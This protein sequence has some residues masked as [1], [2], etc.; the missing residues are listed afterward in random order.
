MN[1][2]SDKV[3]KAKDALSPEKQALFELLLNKRK[4]AESQNSSAATSA[5]SRRP[6]D[7]EDVPL[8]FAQEQFWLLD[9]IAPDS[10]VYNIPMAF[11]IVGA[12]NVTA[13][14]KSLNEVIRRHEVLRSTCTAIDGQPTQRIIPELRLSL[15]I[16]DLSHLSDGERHQAVAK[17]KDDTAHQPFD[18]A[19]GPLIRATLLLTENN[20]E[21]QEHIFLLNLHHFVADGWSMGLFYE[22]LTSLYTRL[23][24]GQPNSD[25]APLPQLPIQYGDFAHWQRQ[26]INSSTLTEQLQFWKE[27]LADVESLTLATDRPRPA[28]QNHHGASYRFTL[29]PTLS[30]ALRSLS[31]REGVTLFMTLM[32]AFQVL[33]Y[34]YTQEEDILVATAVSNRLQSETERLLGSFANNLLLR[35]KV[36]GAETFRDLL[37]QVREV[38]VKA[39]ANQEFPFAQLI[40]ELLPEQE[41]QD[42][43]RNPLFQVMFT[44]H[45]RPEERTLKLANLTVESQPIPM[46]TSK[47]DLSLTIINRADAQT[48]S[49][50]RALIAGFEYNTD[51]F[52]ENTI[53]RMADHYRVL[54]EEVVTNGD[55]PLKEISL[56]TPTERH[57]LLVGWNNTQKDYSQDQCIHQLFEQQVE[58][59]PSAI[60]AVFHDKQLTYG[61][62]NS[63][64]NQLAHYLQTLGLQP[65]EVVG[66]CLERSLEMIVALLAVL[67]AG[68]AYVPLDPHYPADRLAFMMSDAQITVL[69]TEEPCLSSLPDSAPQTVCLQRDWSEISQH[70]YQNPVT[71]ITPENLAYVIYTSG[72]TGTPK[73]VMVQHNSLVNFTH[74]AVETYEVSSTDRVLQFASISFDA[75]AEEIYPCL[76][77]GATLVLRSDDMLSSVTNFL[78]TCHE[79]QLTVLD[80][81]TA[82]WQQ[83]VV[84]LAA[85][86]LPD[87][88]RLVIIGGERVSPEAVKTWQMLV[89][90]SPRLINTYGPT[91]GTVVATAYTITA[92]DRFAQEVP[93]GG[94]IANV[95]TYVLDQHGQPV[96]VGVPGELHIGGMGLAR[97]Y[98]N[99]PALTAERFIAH[100]F[101]ED[102]QARLYKTG[103]LVRYLPDG[104]LEFL[105]RIDQQVKI[106]GFRVELGEI[107]TALAH[108]PMV[109]GAVV[110]A[111]PD[112][113]GSQ[114]LIAYLIANNEAPTAS[115]LPSYLK[116]SL[117]AYMIPSMFVW[118]DSFPLTPSGKIDR[119]VLP[120]P[121]PSQRTLD[122]EF[123]APRTS[124]EKQLAQIWCD[125]L[126]IEQVG[127]YDNFFE[128]GGHSLLATQLLTR[129]RHE[130]QIEMALTVIF[131][132][133]TIAEFTVKL[134]LAIGGNEHNKNDDSDIVYITDLLDE[135]DELSDDMVDQ[136]AV[137]ETYSQPT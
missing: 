117:P 94:A 65:D 18:L 28:I 126:K 4:R 9:Q 55:Q 48:N 81:P 133:P 23:I 17:Y 82:Y 112:V 69:V 29:S 132:A 54:L 57:Q 121:D 93:I 47:L 127:I 96:P 103:D 40:K 51:L 10:P 88:L 36:D 79:W 73:G 39:Y 61:E 21:H 52:D 122:H 14:E 11:R 7:M 68:G 124:V 59:T 49:D 123:V 111:R 104:N 86:T 64:A 80:L 13:L 58:R 56:L 92:D 107:E 90:N 3:S 24:N 37:A 77:T 135:L 66:I 119:K 116:E 128:L 22:E 75:A 100:P 31:Q 113:S 84:E 63:R 32:A 85:G 35:G 83:I 44:L 2:R 27:Q 137:N 102:T 50:N 108:H 72:S 76:T 6:Q 130:Y 105:G 33:L 129:I 118:L 106:R 42:L 71:K 16:I 91:E 98:L 67:K 25:L 70:C 38:A 114:Q 53:Q 134:T 19:T 20:S 131:E 87:S 62:L 46:R 120:E 41:R 74:A 125:L 136:Y 43:S 45:E 12:L 99:R 5:I 15:P 34:R 30:D 8:S 109:Q 78:Q 1:Q 60:A 110:V 26:R 89:G 115:T 101:S 97:G 95:Q